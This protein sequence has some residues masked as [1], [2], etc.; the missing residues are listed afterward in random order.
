MHVTHPIQSSCVI[1]IDARCYEKFQEQ[2]DHGEIVAQAAVPIEETDNE[3]SLHEK[4]RQE[5]HRLFPKAMQQV[6]LML[7]KSK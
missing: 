3:E 6:A 4:I 5:E 2:V 7:L 1:C